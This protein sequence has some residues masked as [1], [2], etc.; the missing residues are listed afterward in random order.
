MN[1]FNQFIFSEDITKICNDLQK[2]VRDFIILMYKTKLS[3]DI[4]KIQFK[5]N[6]GNNF[7]L[8]KFFVDTSKKINIKL[9]SHRS[10]LENYKVTDRQ[11][12]KQ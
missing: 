8:E 3:I 7:Q 12:R 2:K 9:K 4:Y 6:Q 10:S 1:E 5:E 11:Y